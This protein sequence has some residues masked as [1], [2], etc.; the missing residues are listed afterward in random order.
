MSNWTGRNFFFGV[1]SLFLTVMVLWLV[2]PYLNTVLFS[3]TIV[4]LLSPIYNYF[5]R[6]SWVKGKALPTALTIIAFFFIVA[7]PVS[8]LLMFTWYQGKE[9]SP[10]WKPSAS[11]RM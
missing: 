9:L 5:H 11:V 6:L 1:F 8:L 4:V 3:I 2:W 7:I 10:S